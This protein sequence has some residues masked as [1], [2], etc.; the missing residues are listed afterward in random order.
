MTTSTGVSFPSYDNTVTL[1]GTITSPRGTDLRPAV[2]IVVGSGAID[3]DG[4]AGSIRLHVYSKLAEFFTNELGWICL[5]YDKRGVA[6]SVNGDSN[7][8][9]TSGMSDL[10]L[11]V[12]EATKFLLAQ[13]RVDSTKLVLTGHSEGAIIMP[14]VAQ[15]LR[16]QGVTTPLGLLLLSGFGESIETAMRFQSEELWDEIVN[17]RTITTWL[18]RRLLT[19]K[20]LQDKIDDLKVKVNTTP[21]DLIVKKCGLVKIPAKWFREHFAFNLSRIREL[22][23]SVTSHVLVITGAKDAQTRA[24][25]CTRE[26]ASVVF[27]GAASVTSCIPSQMTHH[28]RPMDGTPSLF[29]LMQ[30]Y[31]KTANN[32]LDAELARAITDWANS[33]QKC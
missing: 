9:L 2:V 13:P 12:V 20:K 23:A 30:E 26:D 10:A 11:D 7:L 31:K 14:L 19:P 28:L 24:T 29:S 17:G 16:D 15:H 5:R 25:H 32:P 18:L 21:A 6:K 22:S 8:F 1:S 4:S 3:R 27:V 33:I